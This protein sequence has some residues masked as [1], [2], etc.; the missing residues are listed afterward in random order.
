M[1]YVTCITCSSAEFDILE[2]KIQNYLDSTI[3]GYNGANYA[4]KNIEFSGSYL[5]PLRKDWLE[6]I[7]EGLTPEEVNMIT[8]VNTDDQNWFPTGS[9]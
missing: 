9:F 4:L 5:L 1:G 3:H 6:I 7:K 2:T 8:Q